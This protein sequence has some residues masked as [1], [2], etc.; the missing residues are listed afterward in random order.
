MKKSI[1]I[2]LTVLF[3]AN[4]VYAQVLFDSESAYRWIEGLSDNKFEGRKT[5]LKGGIESSQWIA[6]KFREFGLEP[7]GENKSYFQYFPLLVTEATQTVIFELNDPELGKRIYLYDSDFTLFT[8]SGSGEIE[9]EVIFLGL[10]IQEPDRGWDDVKDLNLKDKILVIYR[11]TPLDGQDWSE[12]NLRDYKMILARKHDAKAVLVYQSET[13]IQGGAIH[14]HAY[15]E[16]IPGLYISKQVLMDILRGSGKNVN[17]LL[18]E[19]RR[20]PNSFHIIDKKIYLN[21]KVKRVANGRGRNVIGVYKGSDPELRNEY[22]VVGGHMDH[23]G[24]S[25][26][27]IIYNGADDNASG[28]A[29]IMELGK[30]V[31][32]KNLNLKRSVIFMGFG[33]EEQGLIGS[34]YFAD[35]PTVPR[36]KIIAMLNFDMVGNGNGGV[37]VGAVEQFPGIWQKIKDNLRVEDRKKIRT[38]MVTGEGRGGTDSYSFMRHFI[39]SFGFYSTGAH[40]FYHKP[41]DDIE[42]INK[43]SLQSTGETA[44]KILIEI[45][46]HENRLSDG[47]RNYRYLF[48]TRYQVDFFPELFELDKE[49]YYR[50]WCNGINGKLIPLKSNDKDNIVLETILKINE[51]SNNTSENPDYGLLTGNRRLPSIANSNRIALILTAVN[52]DIFLNNTALP[53]VYEKLG[54]KAILLQFS[55]RNLFKEMK[56]TDFGKDLI[57]KSFKG[58]IVTFLKFEK[59]ATLYDYFRDFSVLPFILISE[60]DISYLTKEDLN[61]IRKCNSKLIIN[62]TGN[63]ISELTTMINGVYKDII[64]LNFSNIDIEESYSIIKT[65]H[66]SGVDYNQLREL[67]NMNIL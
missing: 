56:V 59:S 39:P 4:T 51:L 36:D 20:K 31:S 34:A 38:F 29:V 13:P 63:N 6:D 43:E 22:I 15:Q 37:G 64:K 25:P 5:G 66:E 32:Q 26:E 9:A 16:D 46:N 28:T 17:N 48:H 3:L 42:L 53:E 49:N 7:G 61:L 27:G 54:L 47:L 41:D 44:L 30:T 18:N 14:E 12:E 40:P 23:V 21:V 52:T 24:T 67:L 50:N 55:D 57:E 45:A 60:N 11:T 10:G 19:C 65:I 1:F 62:I 58:N 35:H 2:S 8:N 33:A